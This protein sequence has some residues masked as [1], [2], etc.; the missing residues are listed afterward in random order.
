[1]KEREFSLSMGRDSFYN[2]AMLIYENKNDDI[3]F[4]PS[5]V[6]NEALAC[7]LSI[8]VILEKEGLEYEKIH[9]LFNLLELLPQEILHNVIV[10]I[11]EKLNHPYDIVW[12]DI[13][14]FSFAAVDW[15]YLDGIMII[16][17]NT[18]HELMLSLYDLSKKYVLYA[19]TEHGTIPTTEKEI[20]DKFAEATI[21]ALNVNAKKITE[22]RI[23]REKQKNKKTT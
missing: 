8:K 20:D 7:E 9:S 22:Q 15:R 16:E 5:L 11:S 14:V 17:Q 2:A 23:K 4:I 21:Q 1:M 12:R 13:Q 3:K 18:L 19:V 10:Q 6:V